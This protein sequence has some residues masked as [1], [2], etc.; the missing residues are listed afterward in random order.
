MKKGDGMMWKK[1]DGIWFAL[2][3]NNN[4][5]N[6]IS[7]KTAVHINGDVNTSRIIECVPE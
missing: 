3:K 2:T 1:I 4:N 7:Q 6:N 5:N